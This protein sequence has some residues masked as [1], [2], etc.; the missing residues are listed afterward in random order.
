ML[1]QLVEIA[2]FLSVKATHLHAFVKTSKTM[3]NICT[4]YKCLESSRNEAKAMPD[5]LQETVLHLCDTVLNQLEAVYQ[6]VEQ[7]L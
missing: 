5:W 7:S 6:Q 4:Y 1:R 3:T 2:D